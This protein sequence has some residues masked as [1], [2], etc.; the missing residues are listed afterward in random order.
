MYGEQKSMEF[1]K[2]D[3]GGEEP[4]QDVSRTVA[5]PA[6]ATNGASAESAEHLPDAPADSSA[7]QPTSETGRPPEVPAVIEH[8]VQVEERGESEATAQGQPEAGV[9]EQVAPGSQPDSDQ[10]QTLLDQQ[11]DEPQVKKGDVLEGTIAHTSPTEI[12]VDVGLKSEGVI[13]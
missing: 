3:V 1:N 11:P 6:E 13:S 12:L 8:D 4:E 10:M 7:D 9:Q 5:P 2:P